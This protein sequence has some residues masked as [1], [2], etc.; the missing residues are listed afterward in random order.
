MHAK[1]LSEMHDVEIVCLAGG[2][3]EDAKAFADQWA[4]PEVTLNY[5]NR[6]MCDDIDAVILATPSPL[7]ARQA[8]QA[9][10]AGKHVLVE[11]PMSL[12]LHDAERITALAEASNRVCMV[13]HTRRFNPPHCEIKRRLRSGEFHLQ[14]MICETVFF[15]RDNRNMHGKTRSWTDNLLWRSICLAAR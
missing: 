6:V 13:A 8:E 9:I 7:H 14:H 2:V 12:N 3:E 1:V 4:I 15:R 11:I 10:I 5:D